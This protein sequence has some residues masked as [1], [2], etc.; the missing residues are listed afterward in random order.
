M[1][2]EILA[3]NGKVAIWAVYN[4]FE[5]IRAGNYIRIFETLPNIRTLKNEYEY[6]KNIIWYYFQIQLIS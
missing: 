5:N 1:S 4:K 3:C 2:K 6:S